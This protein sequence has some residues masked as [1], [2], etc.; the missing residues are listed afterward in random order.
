M[1]FE[2]LDDLLNSFSEADRPAIDGTIWGFVCK[3]I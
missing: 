3:L 2:E 1:A